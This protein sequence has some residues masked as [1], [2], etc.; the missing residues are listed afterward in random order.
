VSTLS[1]KIFAAAA[2]L[3][4]M[5]ILSRMS[6]LSTMSNVHDVRFVPRARSTS[7]REER[8]HARI[9]A[10]RAHDACTGVCVR[11]VCAF[12]NLSSARSPPQ[13]ERVQ[14]QLHQG[15]DRIQGHTHQPRHPATPPLHRLAHLS[16]PHSFQGWRLTG[17]APV[18]RG[19]D[20]RSATCFPPGRRPLSHA[21]PSR[22]PSVRR[23]TSTLSSASAARDLTRV[24]SVFRWVFDA[25]A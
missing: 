10:R 21:F 14:H 7:R 22:T 11:D 19:R 24:L 8:G 12:L 23:V 6:H 13:V 5:S 4:W 15:R 3:P 1:G 17:H 25:L 20:P 16:L 2:K 18:F 9:F